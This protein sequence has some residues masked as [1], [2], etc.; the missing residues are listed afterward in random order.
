MK[1]WTVYYRGT[2]N[3]A[4]DRVCANSAKAATLIAASMLGLS[5]TAYLQAKKG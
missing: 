4:A 3:I 2:S 5:S 1:M